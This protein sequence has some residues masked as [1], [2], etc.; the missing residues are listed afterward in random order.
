MPVGVMSGSVPSIITVPLAFL[1][2]GCLADPRLPWCPRC[3]LPPPELWQAL[4]W[5]QSDALHVAWPVSSSSSPFSL[6]SLGSIL[7]VQRCGGD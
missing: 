2:R 5:V 7:C 3:P 4:W 1:L 6:P